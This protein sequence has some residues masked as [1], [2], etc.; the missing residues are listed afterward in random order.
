MRD[1]GVRP[2][3]HAL[4]IRHASML[5]ATSDIRRLGIPEPSIG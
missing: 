2:Y 3:R 5:G 1:E 4:Q